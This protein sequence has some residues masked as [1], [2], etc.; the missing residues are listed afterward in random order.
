[1]TIKQTNNVKNVKYIE[2]NTDNNF[3]VKQ[4]IT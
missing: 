3:L 4:K 2:N 1:M